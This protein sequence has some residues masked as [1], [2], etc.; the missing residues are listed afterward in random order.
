ML[1][2][3]LGEFLSHLV[4]RQG[5]TMADFAKAVG[6]SPS[7][8]SRVR[9]GQRLPSEAQLQAWADVLKLDREARQQLHEHLLLAR[10]PPAVRARLVQAE[11][12]ATDEQDKRSRLE[13]DYGRYRRDQRYHDGWWLTFSS[14]FQSDGRIQRSLLRIADDRADLQVREYG[15]LHYSYHGS[16]ETL[17]DKVFLRLTEDRGAVEHV[18]ITL[19]SLF[20]YRE[21]SFLYG[22][23]CG[24]SGKDVRHPVSYPA[25]SRMLMMFIGRCDDLPADG[26]QMTR[27][28]SVLGSYAPES[29]RPCWPRFLG[30]GDWFAETLR[31]GDEP[32]DAAILRLI[33]NRTRSGDYVLR[34]T[35]SPAPHEA[36]ARTVP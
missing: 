9:T 12:Q 4:R 30:D 16:F 22:L 2:P 23:V 35:F 24:I 28:Q 8:L 10:T 33:D 25:C 36:E 11:Q 20:D 17:G 14:S 18:Q 21:P 27:V 3:T 32:L 26:E 7:T 31:L 5:Q 13:E 6:L 19:D 29:L 15:R 34:A 1:Q